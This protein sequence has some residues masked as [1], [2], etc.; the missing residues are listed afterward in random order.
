MPFMYGLPPI[1]IGDRTG[2][3]TRRRGRTYRPSVTDR[4][5][6]HCDLQDT[7]RDLLDI[8]KTRAEQPQQGD[9]PNGIHRDEKKS[10]KNQQGV[11]RHRHTRVYHNRD[12]DNEIVQK[13]EEVVDRLRALLAEAESGDLI[14]FA[15][16]LRYRGGIGRSEYMISPGTW[17]FFLPL[18]ASRRA[19]RDRR[20]RSSGR[21]QCSAAT[22]NPA[23]G[24][25]HK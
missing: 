24:E 5:H 15:V 4:G 10:R 16:A 12:V 18:P 3:A 17:A 25:S 21:P 20:Y 2:G 7:G 14:G 13:N 22:L 23:R 8:P 11:P 1:R 9:D 6:E 19:Y